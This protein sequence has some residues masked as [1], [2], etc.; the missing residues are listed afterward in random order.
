MKLCNIFI[1]IS[2][3]SFFFL[4]Q[5]FHLT[6][7]PQ[8]Q[9]C[10]GRHQ[11]FLS[12]KWFSLYLKG[13]DQ[14]SDFSLQM[15]AT[16]VAGPRWSKEPGAPSRSPLCTA[17]MQALSPHLLPLDWRLGSQEA[18]SRHSADMTS[19]IVG[20]GTKSLQWISLF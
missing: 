16:A 19:G 17:G 14:F 6:H 10:C 15:P 2:G 11:N 4:F 9:L 7:I 3:I 8:S 13:R 1:L 5:T 20:C 12:K 18:E